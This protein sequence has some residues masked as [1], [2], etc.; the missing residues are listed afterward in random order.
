MRA[1]EA[2]AVAVV[3]AAVFFALAVLAFELALDDAVT[4]RVAVVRVVLAFSTILCSIVDAP[5]TSPGAAGFNG[6]IGLAR[7]DFI[8]DGLMGDFGSVLEFADRGDST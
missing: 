4:F 5:P 1:L 8:G 7:K 3:A 2:V 6:E